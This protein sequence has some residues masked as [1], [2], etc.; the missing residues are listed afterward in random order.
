MARFPPEPAAAPGHSRAASLAALAPQLFRP[1]MSTKPS[2][3]G[4]GL[5]TAQLLV[6]AHHGSISFESTPGKG[7]KRLSTSCTASTN[8][9]DHVRKVLDGTVCGGV[10]VNDALMHV[11][12]DDLPFGG[13]GQSDLGRGRVGGEDAVLGDAEFRVSVQGTRRRTVDHRA[14]RGTIR[15]GAQFEQFGLEQDLL[16]QLIKART[17]P[18]R[19]FDVLHIAGHLLD[20]DFVF[21][22][23]LADLL[24][25]VL[26]VA[27]GLTHR[28]NRL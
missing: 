25:V 14:F 27:H 8:Q 11:G 4:L 19:N 16:D 28:G 3:F 9:T 26:R 13:V 1:L 7:T 22:Q 5:S 20:D 6:K 21:E 10:T 24:L 12:Q 17:G 23:A 15:I 18:G 2:G